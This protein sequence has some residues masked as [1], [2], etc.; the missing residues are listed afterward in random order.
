MYKMI[1]NRML[2]TLFIF[3]FYHLCA[4][5]KLNFELARKTISHGMVYSAENWISDIKVQKLSQL[6]DKLRN[7]NCFKLSGLSYTGCTLYLF[8][9]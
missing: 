7:D 2:K 6:C 8:Y 9:G 4:A 5:T 3:C 1:D